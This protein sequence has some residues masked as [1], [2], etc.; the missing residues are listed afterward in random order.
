VSA[1]VVDTASSWSVFSAIE[2]DS[3]RHAPCP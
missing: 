3:N 1:A 2:L